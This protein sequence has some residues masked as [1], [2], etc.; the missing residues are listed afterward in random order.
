MTSLNNG[1]PRSSGV[2]GYLGRREDL[3]VDQLCDYETSCRCVK[4]TCHCQGL[5]ALAAS[6]DRVLSEYDLATSELKKAASKAVQDGMMKIEV[7]RQA[8]VTRRTLDA[9]LTERS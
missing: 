4:G 3:Q 2:I 5:K 6:R 9:W 8:N 1:E 7:A